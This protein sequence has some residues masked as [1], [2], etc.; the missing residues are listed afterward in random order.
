MPIRDS[1]CSLEC[2]AARMEPPGNP[3]KWDI[4]EPLPCGRTGKKLGTNRSGRFPFMCYKGAASPSLMSGFVGS[5]PAPAR[6]ILLLF[7]TS[8]DLGTPPEEP[9]RLQGSAATA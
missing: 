4:Q 1:S 8:Q 5:Q 2:R 6:F 9:Q 3:R 7:P